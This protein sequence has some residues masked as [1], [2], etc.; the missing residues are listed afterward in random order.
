[1]NSI[2]NT[3]A[4]AGWDDAWQHVLEASQP[5]QH[6]G[7]ARVTAVHG[8]LVEVWDGVLSARVA[9]GDHALAVGDWVVLDAPLPQ[10]IH[11]VSVLPRRTQLRR[12]AAGQ[13]TRAQDVAANLDELWILT[14]VD[15]DFSLGRMERYVAAALAGGITPRLVLTKADTHPSPALLAAEVQQRLGVTAH[16]LSV[17]TGEGLDV[18]RAAVQPGRTYALVGSSGVGKS[19]LLN[20]LL[21]E[22]VM[23]TAPVRASD[24]TGR[25]TTTVR[26]MLQLPG[27]ALVV[28]TPGMRAFS[29]WL[30]EGDVPGFDDVAAVAQGCRFTNCTHVHEPGCA[31]RA[32]VEAGALDGLRV[33][34]LFQLQAEAD[35]QASRTGRAAHD[36]R[37][38]D[39]VLGRA[40]RQWSKVTGKR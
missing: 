6:H 35:F 11:V 10:A 15:E 21:G 26:Q 23:A 9:P 16:V 7:V 3:H 37:R 5:P 12:Q 31:V 33:D 30:P 14:G 17:L 18:L 13:Q 40:K 25:H 4:Q 29:P 22:E 19:T 27:G 20:A 34:N 38:K 24:H 39:A 8:T 1:M 2:K 32:A 28:D 36:A